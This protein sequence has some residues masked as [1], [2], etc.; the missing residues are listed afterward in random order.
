LILLVF[1]KYKK[2]RKIKIYKKRSWR[3]KFEN[4]ATFL[5]INTSL[6]NTLRRGN[7]E[8]SKKYKKKKKTLN[9]I[10]YLFDWYGSVINP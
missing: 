7:F 6:L 1:K 9:L 3:T 10:P 5:P 4:L 8:T 2:I